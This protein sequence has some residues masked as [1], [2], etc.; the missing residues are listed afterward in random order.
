MNASSTIFIQRNNKDLEI[1]IEG[2]VER[3]ELYPDRFF[4]DV[5]KVDSVASGEIIKLSCSEQKDA[6]QNLIE[7]FEK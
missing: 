3:N 1:Y 7:D 2:N 5:T 6:I 4:V